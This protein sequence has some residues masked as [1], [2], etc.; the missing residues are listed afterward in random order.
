M[1]ASNRQTQIAKVLKILKHHYQPV[2]PPVERPV[3]EHLLYACCLENSHFEAADEGFARLQQSYFD[4]NEVRVTTV[5]ELAE[6]LACLADPSAAA[7]RLKRCLQSVFETHYAFDLEGMKKQ[8]LG[9][10][11]KEIEAL[12]GTTPFTVAYVTQNGL[13]GHAIPC[14]Q[15]VID[16][17]EVLEIITPA[18]AAKRRVPGLERAVAKSKGPELASLLH[19][20]GADYFAAPFDAKV[21]TILAEIDPDSRDRVPSRAA[22]ADARTPSSATAKAGEAAADVPGQGGD[23][24]AEEGADRMADDVAAQ[25]VEPHAVRPVEFRSQEDVVSPPDQPVAGTLNPSTAPDGSAVETD[26]EAK[27][28]T[29]KQ[30]SRKKP[31]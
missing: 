24:I 8:N 22:R 13:S 7:A 10:A 27:K 1:T 23:E 4:W 20:L 28:C 3:L 6:T 30:L 5:T 12:S 31:R 21:R 26:D 15:G 9:K 29:S 19:Q 25:S 11:V 16:A 18:E 14:S 17:F 2:K